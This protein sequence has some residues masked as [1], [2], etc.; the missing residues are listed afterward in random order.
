M[1]PGLL[2]Y[3][4][5]YCI[6]GECWIIRA[7]KK[8]GMSFVEIQS[9]CS[10]PTFSA[11]G[12]KLFNHFFLR[13]QWILSQFCQSKPHVLV[14]LMTE[15]SKIIFVKTQT[16]VINN[17]DAMWNLMFFKRNN[18]AKKSNLE[19]KMYFLKRKPCESSACGSMTLFSYQ[20]NSIFY[21]EAIIRT[22]LQSAQHSYHGG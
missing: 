2:Q 8:S 15:N 19:N 10:P 6:V 9:S 3:L 21:P 4:I 17:W 16:Q 18:V 14:P 7:G 12:W 22:L 20:A 13:M 1:T 11:T 5:R